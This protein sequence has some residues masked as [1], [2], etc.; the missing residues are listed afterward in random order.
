MAAPQYGLD[1]WYEAEK[2]EVDI[3][4]VHGLRGGRES[5]WTKDGCLWPRE[6]LA[7][8]IPDSRIFGFGYDSGVVHSDTAEITQGSTENDARVLCM[9]LDGKRKET[10]TTDRPIVT[11]GHSL[12]GL[13]LAQVLYSGEKAATGDSLRSV[14]D[15]I[16]G[17]LFLGTP[18]YG[19]SIA[20]WGEAVRRIFDVIR[21]DSDR[22]TLKNLQQDSQELKPLRDGF[23]ETIRKRNQSD[24]KV[25][26]VFCYELFKTYGV[27]IVPEDNARYPGV[28]EPI[29]VKANHL[30][31]CKFDD[32]NDDNYKMVK[33]K[34][35]QLKVATTEASDGKGGK[36][37][38][39]NVY[40]KVVNLVNEGD[41]NINHQEVHL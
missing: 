30:G 37:N 23:P 10:N 3:V 33:A 11:V 28:G 7:K 8:D 24:A 21:R 19:S 40:G 9:L 27:M 13:V 5:T 16:V 26:V 6:L 38:T 34:I 41:I 12:G 2:A 1:I 14:A 18:F 25:A 17:M 20:K 22:N 29:P 15:K 36:K 32:E 4:F 39:I 31:I 35:L